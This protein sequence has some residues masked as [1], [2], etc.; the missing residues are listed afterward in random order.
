VLQ[1]TGRAIRGG[2]Y[3]VFRQVRGLLD[4]KL[5]RTTGTMGSWFSFPI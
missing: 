3:A 1:I 5:T 2:L 4:K